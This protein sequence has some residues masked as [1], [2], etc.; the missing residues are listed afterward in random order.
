MI[1]KWQ[2]ILGLTDWKIISKR[3]DRHQV[4]FP[5]NISPRDR[6]FTGISIDG[7]RMKGT[8][9]HD[10]PLTEEAVVH[11]LLHL[12]FPDKEEEWVDGLTHSLV[13]KFGKL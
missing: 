4:V 5:E 7:D 13:D 12:K 11:E 6:Y 10:A 8:I 2:K 1:T 9:Y 3:I